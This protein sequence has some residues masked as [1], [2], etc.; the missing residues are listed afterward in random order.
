M[1]SCKEVTMLHA[2]DALDHASFRTRAGVW[3]HRLMCKHCRRYAR[4]LS[5]IRAAARAMYTSST[6]GAK[7]EELLRRVVRA[8]RESPSL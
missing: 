2:T 7:D 3:V 6:D 1:L 5:R 4:E 8:M